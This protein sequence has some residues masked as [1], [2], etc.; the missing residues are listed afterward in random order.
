MSLDHFFPVLISDVE[1]FWVRMF[2][3]IRQCL[4]AVSALGS[5]IHS[6]Q[7][8]VRRWGFASLLSA[9]MA[10]PPA[11]ADDEGISFLSTEEIRVGKD[12]L[13]R[14]NLAQKYVVEHLERETYTEALKERCE[15]ND[16]RGCLRYVLSKPNDVLLAIPDHPEFQPLR[17]A[18]GGSA[19]RQRGLPKCDE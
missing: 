1:A 4:S 11:F 19:N 9:L 18:H 14:F 16:S 13:E 5:C 7:A 8:I 3:P 10:V 6:R 17:L 12:A 15:S 2:K